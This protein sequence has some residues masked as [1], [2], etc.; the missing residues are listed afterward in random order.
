MYY[1]FF[2]IYFAPP[3]SKIE[4]MVAHVQTPYEIVQDQHMNKIQ[5]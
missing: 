5:E 2:Y 4:S 1:A 3:P